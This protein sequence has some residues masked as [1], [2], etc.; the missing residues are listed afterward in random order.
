MNHLQDL[1]VDRLIGTAKIGSYWTNGP[2]ALAVQALQEK[3]LTSHSDATLA[4]GFPMV[5]CE[6]LQGANFVLKSMEDRRALAA[7]FF[8]EVSPRPQ[9]LKMSGRRYAEIG[10]WC[11]RRIHPLI[12]RERCPTLESLGALVRTY[13]TDGP[14]NWQ[15]LRAATTQHRCETV[16]LRSGAAS[17]QWSSARGHADCA[18]MYSTQLLV[19]APG[20]KAFACYYGPRVPREAVRV[21]ALLQGK[22]G[23]LDFCLALA[24]ELGL[25]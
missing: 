7:A 15:M 8:T 18:L 16:S 5:L 24:K 2:L 23:A 1:I 6:A 14:L 17:S 11:L 13:L 4:L 25:R 20:F 19:V 21:P 9:R 3:Q 22:D 12:C 10:L